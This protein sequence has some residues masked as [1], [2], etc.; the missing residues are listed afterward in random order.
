MGLAPP[1][2]RGHPWAV[3][4]G[5][6]GNV[7]VPEPRFGAGLYLHLY[8]PEPTLCRKRLGC[9]PGSAPVHC[10]REGT[11]EE[12][13]RGPDSPTPPQNAL[14][15]E[16]AGGRARTYTETCM[17]IHTNTRVST[18]TLARR[19]T[20]TR[21]T[22]AL[23]N[24]RIYAHTHTHRHADRHAHSQTRAS[25]VHTQSAPASSLN[26]FLQERLEAIEV[27]SPSPSPGIRHSQSKGHLVDS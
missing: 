9:T 12:W 1:A 18:C 10:E 22:H 19:Y 21:G 15:T 6:R 24:T 20:W 16:T 7:T 25:N 27:P 5:R 17:Q 13:E 8:G 14:T 23:V 4:L 2:S 11:A 3:V 26:F